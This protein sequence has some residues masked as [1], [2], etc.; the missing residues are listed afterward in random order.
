MPPQLWKMVSGGKNSLRYI[1]MTFSADR[2][3]PRFRGGMKMIVSEI[4]LAG[5]LLAVLDAAMRK[6]ATRKDTRETISPSD[7]FPITVHNNKGK[8][9]GPNL[10]QG[11]R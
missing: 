11:V 7:S 4:G 6:H 5:R 2:G 9:R 1:Q 3:L 8:S 10:R